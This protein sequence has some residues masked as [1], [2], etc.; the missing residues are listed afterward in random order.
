MSIESIQTRRA[1][2]VPAALIRLTIPGSEMGKEF[3]RAIHEILDALKAEGI[4]P[5]GPPFARHFRFDPETF[6]FEVGFPVSESPGAGLEPS[7]RM[8]AGELPAA[9]IVRTVHHGSYDGLPAAWQA[10]SERIRDAG[11]LVADEFRERY[12]VGPEAGPDPSHWRTE[13]SWVLKD[14]EGG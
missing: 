2:A 1:E 3:P 8:V 13:L 11:I 9:R 12:V 14:Q 6:D 5:A 7:G 4:T 10:F